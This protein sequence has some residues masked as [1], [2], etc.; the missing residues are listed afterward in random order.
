MT[1]RVLA[2]VLLLV[3]AAG[4]ETKYRYNPWTK[5]QIRYRQAR[6]ALDPHNAQLQVLLANAYYEDK[7]SYRALEHLEKAL[8]LRPGYAEA[9]CN[10]GVILHSQGRL[11]KARKHYERALEGDST[12]VEAKAG[13]GALLCRIHQEVT[14]L[15]FLE[16]VL[17]QEPGRLSARFN[18][19]VA[20]HRIEETAKAIRHL[21]R[22]RQRDP[23]YPGLKRALGSAYY[24]Q[25]LWHLRRGLPEP[26]LED[27]EHAL[28]Y[29][30]YH[31][32][33]FYAK[34][35][36]HLKLHQLGPAEDAF[37]EAVGLDPDHV[38]ALHNLAIICDRTER[39]EESLAYFRQVQLLTSHL[40]TID[41]VRHA[42]Y[43]VGFLVK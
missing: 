36:T 5:E 8:E 1:H 38:P 41:A 24:T 22:V 35:L 3:G 7:Q 15:R 30:R 18:M 13:L 4:G 39:P 23:E 10:I 21:E 9:H 2:L 14:G 19:A 27:F 34:G 37:K 20:Y 12:L 32:N 40:K 6:V 29:R 33:L 28:E 31:A 17:Q 16:E 26:A 43:D 25:G 11:E 42:K